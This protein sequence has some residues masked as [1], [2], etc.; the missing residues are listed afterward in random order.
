M[1]KKPKLRGH[2]LHTS[3]SDSPLEV[4]QAIDVAETTVRAWIRDGKLP[5]LTS[6]NPHL[7]LR[8]DV[9]QFLSS[10]RTKKVKLSADEF[11]CMHCKCARKAWGGMADLVVQT[12]KL[13][14]LHALCEGCCAPMSKG[15]A[16]KDLPTLR[17]LIDIK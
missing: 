6:G 9:V 15:I 14:R 2:G 11:R 10:L 12:A 8:C 5:A 1:P 3:Q 4:G 16:L 13:G 17:K 7:V